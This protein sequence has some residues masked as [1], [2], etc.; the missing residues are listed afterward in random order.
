MRTLRFLLALLFLWVTAVA[1]AGCTYTPETTVRVK[2]PSAVRLEIDEGE[3]LRTLLPPSPTHAEVPLPDTAPPFQAGIRAK[4]TVER[5][6]SGPIDIHCPE[7]APDSK[8]LVP[9]D[10]RMTLGESFRVEKFDFS[11]REMRVHFVDSREGRYGNPSAY[12][13][14]VV[15]PW[16]NVALVRRV[17]TPDRALGVKLLLSAAIGAVLGGL[18]LGD[19]VAGGHPQVTIFGAIVLPLAAILAVSGGWYAF[20]P[21]EEHVLFRGR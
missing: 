9:L 12:E 10:G 3:G 18:S 14:D 11:Q 13:A 1:P 16:T 2:D 19:G 8:T 4:T 5:V 20:A 6:A 21:S 17:S 7:C 15:T